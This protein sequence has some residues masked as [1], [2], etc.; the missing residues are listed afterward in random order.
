MIDEEA[1]KVKFG[2]TSDQLSQ[3]SHKRIIRQCNICG[4]K[5]NIVFLSKYFDLCSSCAAKERHKQYI[6]PFSGQHLSL[7]TKI[8]QSCSLRGIEL[9][10]F[11]DFISPIRAIFY[12]SEENKHWR[13]SIFE[14]DN[15]ICQ[16]CGIRGGNLNVHHILPYRDWKE[17]EYSLNIDNGITLCV[18]CHRK[19]FGKEYEFFSKYFDIINGVNK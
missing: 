1:T 19:T 4:K 7:E 10:Q 6:H 8:K 15:Y 3:W 11:D 14:R 18:D 13:K 5:D 17:P 12:R 9:D 16:E 2:Y